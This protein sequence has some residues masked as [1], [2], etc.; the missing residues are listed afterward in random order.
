M[1]K[2]FISFAHSQGFGNIIMLTD[3]NIE[4]E[5]KSGRMNE[6]HKSIEEQTG[7][8]SAAILYFKRL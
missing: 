4:D 5:I 3:M 2:Y 1:N 8:S 6:L 7:A